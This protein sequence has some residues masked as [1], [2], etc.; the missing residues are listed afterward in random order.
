MSDLIQIKVDG[1]FSYHCTG[2]EHDSR[3]LGKLSRYLITHPELE[4]TSHRP[5]LSE[6]GVAYFPDRS[7]DKANLKTFTCSYALADGCLAV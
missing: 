4:I 2:T 7:Q 3:V 6:L 5:V 1:L